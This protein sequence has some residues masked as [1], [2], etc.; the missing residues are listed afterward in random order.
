MACGHVPLRYLHRVSPVAYH[1]LTRMGGQRIVG[2]EI[3]GDD[4]SISL[5]AVFRLQFERVFRTFALRAITASVRV[6]VD[7]YHSLFVGHSLQRA[8]LG[9][10]KSMDGGASEFAFGTLL[11][12]Q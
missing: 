2:I 7:F 9:K 8:T 4:G 10:E 12:A 6:A 1:T 11:Q 5:V 3:S